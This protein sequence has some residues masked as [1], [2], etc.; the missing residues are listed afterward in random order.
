M[1]GRSVKSVDMTLVKTEEVNGLDNGEKRFI[2]AGEL[3]RKS[4]EIP[5]DFA[6]D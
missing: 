6:I 2:F 5:Q 4:G 1:L 3:V